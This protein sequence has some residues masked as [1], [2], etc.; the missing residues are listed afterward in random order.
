MTVVESCRRFCG[1][2]RSR[3]RDAVRSLARSVAPLHC[4][5]WMQAVLLAGAMAIGF[6]AHASEG[7][8]LA[9]DQG[10]FNC[11][12]AKARHAP[13]L[14][15]LIDEM[16]RKG[17]Q[18]EELQ[19]VLREIRGQKSIHSHQM[20]SDESALLVLRWLAQGGK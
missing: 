4:V 9:S 17:D 1:C 6:S 19:H 14:G 18:D 10:C 12:S 15:R 20:I 13:P 7:E 16:K 3:S 2:T 8:H 5:A 11:H